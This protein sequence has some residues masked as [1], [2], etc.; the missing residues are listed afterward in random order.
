MMEAD[1]EDYVAATHLALAAKVILWTKFKTFC[2]N[3]FLPGIC[4]VLQFT[5]PVNSAWRSQLAKLY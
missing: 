1:L 2:T 4:N 3:P 5:I